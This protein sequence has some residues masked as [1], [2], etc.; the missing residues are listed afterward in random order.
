[1][2]LGHL[3]VVARHNMQLYEYLKQEFSGEPVTVI[4][5]RRQGERRE[6]G[7]PNGEDGPGVERRARPD[8]DAALEARGFVVIAQPSPPKRVD[9]RRPTGRRGSRGLVL[10]GGEGSSCEAAPEGWAPVD[11]ACGECGAV[12][13]RRRKMGVA[14]HLTHREACPYPPAQ[15]TWRRARANL[16]ESH[17]TDMSVLR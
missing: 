15:W 17:S 10:A 13:P 12:G 9:A 4:L 14:C 11:F 3:F 8:V 16:A 6:A 1:M 7:Q 5:D 2:A